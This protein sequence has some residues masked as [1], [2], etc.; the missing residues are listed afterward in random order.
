MVIEW[1]RRL[2]ALVVL[3][4]PAV[5]ARAEAPAEG[6]AVTR[7][8]L[9]AGLGG[10]KQSSRLLVDWVTRF[11]TVLAKQGGLADGNLIVLT[12]TEDPKAAPPR[13][14]AT[15]ENFKAAMD[16]MAKR[17]RPKDQFLLFMAGHG[18]IHEEVGKLCLPGSD[19]QAPELGDLLDALPT[20]EIV[21]INA[22]SGGADFLKAYLRPGRVIL[23]AAGYETEGTQ[24]YFAEFFLQGL[25]TG[26]AD[27]SGDKAVDLLEAYVYGAR[28]TAHFYHR[29]YLVERPD[30]GRDVKPAPGKFYWLVRGKDTRAIW[31]KL[32]ADTDN[33]LAR[34]QPRPGDDGK[35]TDGLPQDLDA[36]P[37]AEPKFGRFDKHWA[38]R[39]MLAEHARL[40]DSGVSKDAF[41]LWK[42]YEFQ[43][44][45]KDA[46]PGQTGC[47]ARQTVLGRPLEPAQA[48]PKAK[49][50]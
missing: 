48:A 10:S 49:P 7:A 15:L 22:A 33:L 47:L 20:D 28:E 4:L 11:H 17:L 12:E 23:T 18:Q 9:L 2:L 42:P 46:K 8:V 43:E 32:Y 41:F 39:R 5:A 16:T 14:Q 1:G 38:F 6:P 37:D 31:K 13:R 19:L 3:V 36:E 40:D 50:K 34:P 21:I 29:Q 26:R 27:S 25:E 35:M 45:P 44:V 30:L 24:T